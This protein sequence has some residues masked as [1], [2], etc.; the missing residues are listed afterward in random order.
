M[1]YAEIE[2][3]NENRLFCFKCQKIPE[4]LNVNIDN[5]K[6][7]MKC[8]NCGIF[9][10][11]VKDYIDRLNQQNINQCNCDSKK[12]VIYYCYECKEN[13]CSNCKKSNCGKY[14]E[15]EIHHYIE[16]TE[17]R[18]KCP[19][20]Y[21]KDITKFCVDCQEN[22]C[23]DCNMHKSHEKI[24]ISELGQDAS[25]DKDNIKNEI[26]NLKN[27]KQ[28]YLMISK[29]RTKEEKDKICEYIKEEKERNSKQIKFLL[30]S[31]KIKIKDHDKAITTLEDKG[32]NIELN[33]EKL[34]LN[35][36]EIDNKILHL[37]SKIQF[38][39]LREIDLSKNKIINIE[40]LTRMNLCNLLNLNLSINEIENIEAIPELNEENIQIINLD[41][42][43][44]KDIKPFLD[45][46]FPKLEEL[47]IQ[48]NEKIEE[49]QKKELKEKIQT[50]KNEDKPNLKLYI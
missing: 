36:R 24:D 45:F 21:K 33:E 26:K 11:N 40:P 28:F 19:L 46:E 10:C 5:G 47:R 41:H 16:V 2:N 48:Q 49:S 9:E 22:L 17:R 34:S 20:H 44:I 13:K 50:N 14:K 42:N 29:N 38:K 12:E 8:K 43:K 37:I 25:I 30:D 3:K 15:N 1:K 35:D 7:E 31:K 6:I 39:N 18:R 27:M 4:I 32:I 23:S